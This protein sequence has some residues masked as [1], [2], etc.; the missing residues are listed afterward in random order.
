MAPLLGRKPYPLVK[1]LAEP[2]GPGE[3]Y[4]IEHTKEA[5]TN[6]DEYEERLQKYSERIWTCKS[7]GSSQLTHREAWDEEQE[8]TE[9]LQEEYPLW[10]EK[11]VLDIVHHNTISL[12]KLVDQVWLEI[13]T[14]YA[15]G[16]ECDFLVGGQQSRRVKVLK[17][18]PPEPP[19]PEEAAAEKKLE[20]ACD[21]PSSDKENTTQEN[22]KKEAQPREEGRR[23]SLRD[24]ARRSPDAPHQP[25]GGEEEVGHAQISAPQVRRAADGRGEGHQQRSRRQPVPHRTPSH[26]GDHALLHQ[27]QRP[28]AG[29][30]R[31]RPLGGGG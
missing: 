27:A 9:L 30:C 21:S 7:T 31:Q 5:F 29:H 1:P 19:P 28:A 11:P 17:V 24:R 20:G 2:P 14:K 10:F 12:D 8:V 4:T 16:E 22:Q 13:L 23:E 26:Q 15:V 6:K 25:E 3:V 18:H